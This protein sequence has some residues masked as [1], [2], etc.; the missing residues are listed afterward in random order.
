MRRFAIFDFRFLIWRKNFPNLRRQFQKA[1]F[2]GLA[3]F[4]L[5]ATV[6]A[7]PLRVTTWNIE[8]NLA[9]GTNG[10]STNYQKNLIQETAEV[11][12][13]LHP[14][15]VVLQ[16]V[17]DWPS[18]NELVKSLK[19]A[20]YNVAAWSS[21]RD[22]HTGTLSPRQTAILTKTKAY[23]SWSEAWKNDGATAAP[24]GFAFAAIRFGGRNAGFF[25]AQLGGNTLL[26][27]AGRG[28][29]QQS[30]REESA[31]QL[32]SQIGS[33]R[34]WSTNRIQLLVVAGDFNTSQDEPA[35]ANEKTLSHLEQ[36][37]LSNAFADLPSGKRVT[38]P[39]S[40]RHS[41]ATSDYIFTH[42]ARPLDIPEIVPTALTEHYPV[43]CDLELDVPPT[44]PTPAQIALMETPATKTSIVHTDVAAITN[45]SPA[46]SATPVPTTT[47]A[48]AE[49]NSPWRIA[50]IAAG[51]I[52]LVAII[53]KLAR[54]R[55]VEPKPAVLLRMKTGEGM[56]SSSSVTP[57][58]I[59]ITPRSANTAGSAA[60]HPP[61]V[62]IETADS[63][64]TQVWQQRAEEAERRAERATAVVRQGLMAHL[65]EWL[66]GMIVQRLVSDRAKLLETQQL[67]AQKMQLVDE[68][69]SKIESQLQERNR[70][71][72]KRIEDLERE[73]SGARE[74]N[75]ELIRAKIAQV[76]A[77]MEKE[78]A[79]AQ[80]RT[81]D[82]QS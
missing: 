39:G 51:G 41:D 42:D 79:D 7:A 69:L 80:R 23:I 78:R 73:L 15:V 48:M 24:G 29:A 17:P 36:A 9:A 65:S 74:E 6:S 77:E 70:V 55:R 57:G 66:K 16:G 2:P 14:D 19:P 32:L 37:G 61:I 8:P 50:G 31:R 33:L 71:Y 20:K 10:T 4:L 30:A 18:C 82:K 12:K 11:L 46:P 28:E 38:L 72:E 40:S 68:R 21:F 27:E 56:S 53:W 75:R 67:A 3:L 22:L 47:T 5:A 25:S 58:R 63:G 43:T 60:D 26:G 64:Q 34:N 1:I 59:V 13:K 35:L 52:L 45:I 54:R 81:G 76:K 62:H 49:S 44:P